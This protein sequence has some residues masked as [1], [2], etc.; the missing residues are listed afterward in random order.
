MRKKARTQ[1]RA[2]KNRN[3]KVSRHLWLQAVDEIAEKLVY[4]KG[5]L[6]ERT[7]NGTLINQMAHLACFYPGMLAL[8]MVYMEDSFVDKELIQE[9][10]GMEQS[11]FVYRA[12]SRADKYGM[13]DCPDDTYTRTSACERSVRCV[14]LVQSVCE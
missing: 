10:I 11:R 8:T 3:L 13:S 1:K 6:I 12:V 4:S 2:V 7:V 9:S 5:H 14:I